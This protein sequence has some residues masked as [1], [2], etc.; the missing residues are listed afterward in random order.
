MSEAIRE[1]YPDQHSMWLDPNRVLAAHR[2]H[3]A[4]L[5]EHGTE[6]VTCILAATIT[7]KDHLSLFRTALKQAH[8][9]RVDHKTAVHV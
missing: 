9:Q 5:I 6:I 1:G 4:V 7:V 8:L 2:S 3:Y